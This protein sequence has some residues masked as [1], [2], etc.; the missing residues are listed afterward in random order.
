MIQVAPEPYNREEIDEILDKKL[1]IS[2]QIDAYS[3]IEDDA[4]LSLKANKTELIDAYSKIE[5]DALLDDKLNISD[6]IDAYSKTE[7]DALLLLKADKTELDSYVDLTSTQTITGRKQYGIII[8]DYWWDGTSLRGLETELQ[9]MS[10]IMT[11]LGAATGG[12]NAITDLS[13]DENTLIPAKN[14]SFITTNYDETIIGQKSFNT[15]FRSVGISVQNYDYKSVVCAGGGIKAIQDINASTVADALLDDKL[16]VSNQIDSYT[17]GED[18]ALL[19]LKVD[20]TQLIEAYSKTE[21]DNLLNNI[22]E[23]GV[24]YTQGENDE[25][26]L[27]KVDKTQLIDS[28]TKGKADNLLNYKADSGISYTK[29]EDDALLLLKSDKTQLI[30]TNTKG[31]ADNLL[32]TKADSGVT[33]TKGENDALLLLKSDKTQLI[34]SYSKGEAA[35]LLNIKADSGVSYTKGEDNATLLLKANQ[36]TTYTK[37][38]TDY[39]ISQIEVGDVNLSGYMTLGTAQTITANKMFNNAYRFINFIDEMATITGS[40]FVKSGADNSVVLFGAG[41]TKPMSEFSSSVDDS[42][43]VKKKIVMHKVFK[44]FYEN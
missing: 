23:S 35:N 21:S 12:G 44:E 3:K 30:D 1:N 7:D 28:Y 38:E 16:N 20:K 11:I 43:Y 18:D 17:K 19:S 40:S 4:L 13:F 15:T 36:S 2:D 31:K 10:N 9:D 32:N 42:N 6:Q 39:L 8:M 14:S 41:G 37:T 29:G 24:S 25:L 34:D 26:L 5:A 33:Y 22:A 27:L